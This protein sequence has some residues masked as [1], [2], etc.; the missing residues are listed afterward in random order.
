MNIKVNKLSFSYTKKGPTILNNLSLDIKDKSINVILGL[1]GSGKTTLIKILAGLIQPKCGTIVYGKNDLGKLSYLERSKIVSYVSQNNRGT[2]DIKVRD[3]L[4]YGM[5]NSIAFYKT[6]NVLHEKK[7]NQIVDKLHIIHLLD[8]TLGT[9][10]GGERQIVSIAS[11]LLQDASVILLD[12][13]TSAL[14]LKNQ[15]IVLSILKKIIKKDKKT[16]ILTTH[17]PNH[18]LFLDA[19]VILINKGSIIETGPAK[20]IVKI[21][22]LKKIYGKSI[23]LSSDLKYKE[24]SFK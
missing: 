2:E 21:E 12:E 14:D 13:P 11:S 1:N 3:Y 9:I 4:T 8:K 23:K 5:L 10:S 19:N 16:I 17:N 24:V 6:P 18:A 20:S 22:K 15:N 7:I